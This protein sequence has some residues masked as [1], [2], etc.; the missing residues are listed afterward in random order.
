V[1][2]DAAR[3]SRGE[4]ST[5][6][7]DW[8]WA[9]LL[10]LGAFVVYV[11]T[12]A[13]GLVSEV[14]SPMFQF[15]GRVLGVAH[16]PGYPFYVL[17]THPFSYV[18][19]GSLAYRLNLFSALLGSVTVALAFM[20][21]RKL[22]CRRLIAAAVALG[23][24][25]GDVFW[26][27]SV[28]AEVYTLYAATLSGI[29][30]ALLTWAETRRPV[31]YYV[32]VGLLA[33]GL[34]NH[35]TIVGFAP[36]IALFVFLT[37]R[38]FAS[39][40]RTLFWTAALLVAGLLQYGFILLRS[41]QPDAYVES[42]ARTVGQ[43]V[44]VM[45]GRQFQERLFSYGWSTVLFER[46]PRVIWS[47]LGHEL[48]VV[49]LAVAGIGVAAILRRRRA[50]AVL[51]LIGSTAVI[52]FAV[53]YAVIDTPVFLIPAILVLWLAAGVGAEQIVRIVR[54]ASVV[55]VVTLVLWLVPA[56]NLAANYASNDRSK[57]TSAAVQLDR[58]FD[59]LPARTAIVQED[60]IVDRMVM[61]KLLGDESARGRSIEPASR[62]ADA[63]R[64]LFDDGVRV[65][66]FRKSAMLLRYEGL[67]FGFD[68]LRLTDDTLDG[69]LSRQPAGTTVALA[70]PAR[71]AGPFAAARGVSLAAI[72]GPARLTT[73][74]DPSIAVVGVVGARTGAVVQVVPYDVTV[75]LPKGQ[76]I[77]DT[78]ATSPATIEASS[79]MREAAIRQGMR[80]LVRTADGVTLTTWDPDGH[81][82][83]TMV[84]EEAN[85]FRV[86]LEI[87]P[88][89]VY[90]LRGTSVR[91]DLPPARWNDIS[92][93][94]ATGSVLLRVPAGRQLI[95]YAGDDRP[96]EPRVFDRP[97]VPVD[98][99]VKRFEGAARADL[100]AQ[101]Q[102]DELSTSDLTHDE[103]VYR[104]AIRAPANVAA[105]VIL[106]LGGI[107]RHGTARVD[108]QKSGATACRI[109]TLGL[110]R[111]PDRAT[112]LLTMGRD[113]QAQLIG[114]GW[115]PVDFDA[116]GPFRWMS[117]TEARF[118]LP[119]TQPASR[120]IR[121]QVFRDARSP[122]NTLRLRLN[123][124]D[125]PWQ[126]LR[127]GWN[128]Y[129]WDVPPGTLVHGANEASLLVDRLSDPA[130]ENGP[131]DVA[132]ADLRVIAGESNSPDIAQN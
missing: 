59:A 111:T 116:A 57:D 122:A 50:E 120:R 14:D 40:L 9:A 124:T 11:R 86:P 121:V 3:T 22:Q 28:I 98:V 49:G 5:T 89:S 76:Q 12:L 15:I 29:V 90:P 6:A 130:N 73:A 60:F 112:E 95:V 48:T 30:L 132:L 80:D 72:G 26:S 4:T 36:G 31:W 102:A 75:T 108:G 100:G 21:A 97:P 27:Q 94:L 87:G 23:L 68:P 63:V 52:V 82:N 74:R 38:A 20:V 61:F 46:V 16:N 117:S 44:K 92:E 71:L 126:P 35:T 41:H 7:R 81:I 70:V 79:G 110:L 42:P 104:L 118:V 66:G 77:G 78:G 85:A 34:G 37:D 106:A 67:D 123:A 54:T 62:D 115:S 17:I 69:F 43:L 45:L 109:D 56:W 32:A 91:Q 19:V 65:F 58:L 2:I 33:A 64:G 88:L 107:P 84:L 131:R 51:L 55:P 119:V 47:V 101:L 39:R 83:R 105:S 24:A 127:S 114:D 8:F 13:P 125:L 18:P 1:S 113:E 10:G 103:N 96:L 128:A 93:P 53:N 99:D 129:E 25:F